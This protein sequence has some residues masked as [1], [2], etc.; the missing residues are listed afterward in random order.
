MES[1]RMAD[2]KAHFSDLISRVAAGERIV[3]RRRERDVAVLISPS[4]LEKIE[5]VARSAH[6][7]AL[8]LGQDESLLQRIERGESHPA[9]AAFGLWKDSPDLANLAQ[10]IRTERDRATPRPELDL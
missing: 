3:V 8:A 9:M 2:A 1:V 10:E 5:R 7:L 4:E 6:R